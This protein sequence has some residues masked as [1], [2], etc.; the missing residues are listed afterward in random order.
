MTIKLLLGAALVGV[1]L[2]HLAHA[3]RRSWPSVLAVVAGLAGLFFVWNPEAAN[4]VA[5]AVGVGRGAD[6]VFYLAIPI[7]AALFVGVRVRLAQQEAAMTELV[8]ALALAGAV[9]P[10]K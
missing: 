6:L 10:G 4:A 9:R 7:A 3:R 5:E 1:V 8:R 2:Y